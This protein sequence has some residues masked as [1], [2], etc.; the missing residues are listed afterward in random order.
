MN[1]HNDDHSK[2]GDTFVAMAIDWTVL[3]D[4]PSAGLL[5]ALMNWRQSHPE[6]VI[7]LSQIL[8]RLRLEPV[9]P[10]SLSD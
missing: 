2:A 8:M 6:A 3:L 5:T 4:L 1:L 7:E 10:E 9:E